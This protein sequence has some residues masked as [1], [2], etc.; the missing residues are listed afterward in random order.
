M[1]LPLTLAIVDGLLLGVGDQT[2]VMP[3]TS[4]VESVRPRADE[5]CG[6]AACGEVVMVRKE[7]LPLFRLAR[8]FHVQTDVDDPT[9]GLVVIVE[10]EGRRLALLV[11]DLLGQ[12]QVVV[13]N[14]EANFKRVEGI[15]GATIF[16]DGRAGLILDVA[17]IAA[18]ATPPDVKGVK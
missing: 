18:L 8:L 16:G 2:Y 4:I 14:L 9:H 12:Q 17:G 3:L 5:V 15:A 1:K 13:K 10:H 6:V 7:P 11:D